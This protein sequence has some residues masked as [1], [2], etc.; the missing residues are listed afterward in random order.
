EDTDHPEIMPVPDLSVYAST[1]FQSV[2]FKRKFP[3]QV[4]LDWRYN[5]AYYERE[6]NPATMQFQ[7][8]DQQEIGDYLYVDLFFSFR[9]KSARMFM[10]MQHINE[11]LSDRNYFLVPYQPMPGRAFRFGLE[12]KFND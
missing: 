2:L 7:L 5:T 3:V 10:K 11:G 8:Q 9:I 4:G 1:Y 6:Y 12:W